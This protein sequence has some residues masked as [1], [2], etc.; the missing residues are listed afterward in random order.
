MGRPRRRA[1]STTSRGPDVGVEDRRDVAQRGLRRGRPRPPRASARPP[2]P[3][4]L[5]DLVERQ[6]GGVAAEG[7]V[8]ERHHQPLALGVHQHG[9][10]RRPRAGTRRTWR[11]STPASAARARSAAPARRRRP[12]RRAAPGRRGAPPPPRRWSPSRAPPRSCRWAGS[13][14]ARSASARPGRWCRA[15]RRRSRPPSP[16]AGPRPRPARSDAARAGRRSPPRRC[17]TR[18][19][20]PPLCWPTIGAGRSIAGG[21]A[22]SCTAGPTTLTVPARGCS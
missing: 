22:L 9:A 4:P 10:D 12:G 6:P 14:P 21:V 7:G 18:A 2:G 19:G 3:R 1:P 20:S 17:R 16:C 11:K 5:A 15:S 13:C 8:V